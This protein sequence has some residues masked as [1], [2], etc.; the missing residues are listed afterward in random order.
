MLRLIVFCTFLNVFTVFANK[1]S[2][3]WDFRMKGIDIAFGPSHIDINQ[4]LLQTFTYSSTPKNTNYA[5][6]YS[7]I[8]TG[9]K[10]DTSYYY[11]EN[12][13]VIQPVKVQLSAIFSNDKFLNNRFLQR[14]EFGLY[15]G[16]DIGRMDLKYQG[17]K[18]DEWPSSEVEGDFNIRYQVQKIG[19][20]YQIVSKPIVRNFALFTG[21]SVDYGILNLKSEEH[22][23]R[24]ENAPYGD[25]NFEPMS[26][27]F[28][29]AELDVLL[30]LKYNMACDLNLFIQ[31][32][33]GAR[34]Y[35]GKH[36]VLNVIYSF[37]IGMR[38]KFIDEQDRPNYLNSGFW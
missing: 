32:N 17:V 19:F 36:N 29:T 38:Y 12:P 18:I 37:C 21:L 25:A 11:Y 26:V 20:L 28:G 5:F 10:R 34:F 2:T 8:K 24:V 9:N 3:R 6:D 35:G 14:T 31:Y 15:L 30:G 7:D 22:K 23:T 16:V 27:S 33:H 1:D 4:K 13:A